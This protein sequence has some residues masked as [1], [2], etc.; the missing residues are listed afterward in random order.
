MTTSISLASNPKP[1]LTLNH[2]DGPP[3]TCSDD[4]LHRLS[5]WE[6]LSLR[7]GLAD[8]DSLDAKHR[9]IPGASSENV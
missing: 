7:F 3:L 6:V 9:R 4:T 2:I 8:I 5:L 1:H